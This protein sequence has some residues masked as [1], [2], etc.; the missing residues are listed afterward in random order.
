MPSMGSVGDGY[1]NAMAESLPRSAIF[2]RESQFREPASRWRIV[3]LVSTARLLTPWIGLN[4]AAMTTWKQWQQF[5]PALRCARIL[6]VPRI[7]VALR[8]IYGN[9]TRVP[10]TRPLLLAHRGDA[11]TPARL[12]R[13]I[14]E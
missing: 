2:R 6:R 4:D 14:L 5:Q 3:A 10:K 12:T 7:A 8:K 9:C 11:D 1:D 13:A